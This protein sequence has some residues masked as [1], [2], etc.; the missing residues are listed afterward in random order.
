MCY[1][2][3]VFSEVFWITHFQWFTSWNYFNGE[4][5]IQF[6]NTTS[7]KVQENFSKKLL[8]IFFEK[9]F[10]IFGKIWKN[11]FLETGDYGVDLSCLFNANF[12]VLRYWKRVQYNDNENLNI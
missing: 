1:W 2:K 8:L 9:N 10:E 7:T 6:L 12:D 4:L 5:F 3:N 11:L